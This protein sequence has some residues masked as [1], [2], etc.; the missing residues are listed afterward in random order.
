MQLSL[1]ETI[2]ADHIKKLIHDFY[3]GIKSDE[4]LSPLYRDGFDIAE[5]PGLEVDKG[6][7]VTESIRATISD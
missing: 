5:V 6:I 1:Y 2:G 4:K 3:Q 7:G